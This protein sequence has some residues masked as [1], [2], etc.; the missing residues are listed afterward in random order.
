MNR[1]LLLPFSADDLKRYD[2][3][4]LLIQSETLATPCPAPFAFIAKKVGR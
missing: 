2:N 3:A 1:G 4:A